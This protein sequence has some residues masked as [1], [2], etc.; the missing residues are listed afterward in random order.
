MTR[1]IYRFIMARSRGFIIEKYGAKFWQSFRALSKINFDSILP[2]V[3]DIGESI[4]SFNYDFGPPYIAWYKSFLSLGL[5]Q[6]E[7]IENIWKM[8]EKMATAIPSPFL[9]FSGKSY[10]NGFRK[11]A[12][13]HVKRQNRGE[14]HPYDWKVTYREIDK[15][16]FEIDITECAMKK[17]SH[18]FDA[19]GLLPGICRMD[20]LFSSVMG[21]GFVR[22]KT[23][24]DGDD[25]C[26]CHYE[27]EGKCEWS[28][29][30]G[31]SERK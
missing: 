6:E 15:N 7:T 20:Y 4:F 1:L 21:N 29:E 23:L 28:P 27:L 5:S 12:A 26:N 11:K 31:F 13:A 3:P 2:G 30:K 22:T 25:C 24:G 8:N 17:L 9:H 14:L 10:M 19:D 18:D 16:S